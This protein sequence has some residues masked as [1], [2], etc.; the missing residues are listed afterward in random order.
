MSITPKGLGSRKRKFIVAYKTG[1][2]SGMGFGRGCGDWV[3]KVVLLLQAK[4]IYALYE[5]FYVHRTAPCLQLPLPLPLSVEVP[6]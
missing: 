6:A 5:K 3:L 4:E 2:M 1:N